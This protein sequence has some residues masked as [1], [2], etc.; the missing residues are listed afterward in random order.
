MEATR[1]TRRSPRIPLACAVVVRDKGTIWS[2]ET[3]DVGARG[4]RIALARLLAR[5]ALVQLRFERGRDL[6]PLEALGQVVWTRTGTALSAGVTFVSLPHDGQGAPARGWIDDLVAA[7]LRRLLPDYEGARGALAKLGAVKVEL[8]VP[9]SSGLAGPEVAVVRFVRQ[10]AALAELCRSR[11]VLE[12]LVAL[13]ERGAVS[14]CRANP[15]PEGWR[16]ALAMPP[17]AAGA[18]PVGRTEPR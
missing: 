18:P 4:C 17:G 5:D 11:D 16:R 8:G 9:P 13:L 7:H 12:V 3:E 10:G 1:H 6:P 15:D 2:T 14:V